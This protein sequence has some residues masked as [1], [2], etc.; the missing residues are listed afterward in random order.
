MLRRESTSA[1]AIHAMRDFGRDPFPEETVS[2]SGSG[3]DAGSGPDSSGSDHGDYDGDS[4]L[5][6]GSYEDYELDLNAMERDAADAF[7]WDYGASQALKDALHPQYME[8][9]GH[10]QARLE[11]IWE[12]MAGALDDERGTV[13]CMS[14]RHAKRAALKELQETL[15]LVEHAYSQQ[16]MNWLVNSIGSDRI[17]TSETALAECH[18]ANQELTKQAGKYHA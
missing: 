15:Q 14:S 10:F 18:A 12:Q 4:G 9:V 13:T 17:K 1:H 5:P 8:M 7:F 6:Y 16:L 2:N 3:S 11:D